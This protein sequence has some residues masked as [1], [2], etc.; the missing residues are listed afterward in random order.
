MTITAKTAAEAREIAAGLRADY[1]NT[2]WVVTIYAPI[3]DGDDYR[4]VGG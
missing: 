1:A 2:D 3:F 4:V